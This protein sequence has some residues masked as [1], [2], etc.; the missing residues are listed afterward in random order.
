MEIVISIQETLFESKNSYFS[1]EKSFSI[2]WIGMWLQ[3]F[4][5][6]IWN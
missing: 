5:F 6:E 4:L 1:F 3:K 2:L